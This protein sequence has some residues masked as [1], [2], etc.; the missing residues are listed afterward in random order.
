MRKT[1][2][3]CNRNSLSEM[4]SLQNIKR[5]HNCYKNTTNFPLDKCKGF[6]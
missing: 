4:C 1:L 3:F 2:Y 5:Y 6:K